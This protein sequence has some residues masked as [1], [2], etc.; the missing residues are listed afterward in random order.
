MEE[1]EQLIQDCVH[2]C[3]RLK[4]DFIGTNLIKIR[5]CLLR[6]YLGEF[7][8]TNQLP[9]ISEPARITRGIQ[10][11]VLAKQDHVSRIWSPTSESQPRTSMDILTWP[12]SDASMENSLARAVV[13]VHETGGSN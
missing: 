9:H 6:F 1:R 5:I 4:W 13:D 3:F 2:E 12:A 7:I 10:S 8:L 11:P